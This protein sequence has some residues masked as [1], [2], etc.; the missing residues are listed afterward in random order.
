MYF[1]WTMAIAATAVVGC[2]E[3]IRLTG[4]TADGETLT[5]QAVAGGGFHQ[6]GTMQLV[7]NRG[8]TCLGTYSFEGMSGPRGTADLTCSNGAATIAALDMPS[9][10]GTGTIGTIPF[11]FRW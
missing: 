3:S 4:S 11:K 10:T 9:R 5:G 2:T 7:G 6:A 8:L 1:R